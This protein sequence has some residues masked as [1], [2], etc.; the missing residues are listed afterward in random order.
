MAGIIQYLA[1]SEHGFAR[2]AR[3]M[4]RAVLNVTLPAPAAV[5]RP[6]LWTFLGMR[7]AYHFV[8]RVAFC[9]PLFKAYCTEYGSGV[10]TGVFL[11]WVQ[12]SGSIRLGNRVLLDGKS[13]FAFTSQ[14]ISDPILEIGDNT[15]VGH[16]CSF[17][18]GRRISIG[19]NCL[20]ARGVWMFDVSGH[21]TDPAER[22]A[23]KPA[24]DAT[25]RPITI[26]DNVWIGMGSQILPG[27]TIGDGAV[28]A[29]GSVVRGRV[30]AN[31]IVAGNPAVEVRELTP[32]S[33]V[34][35]RQI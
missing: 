27:T 1:R 6:V 22:L 20:I 14:Y 32:A 35:P 23:G 7:T 10:R 30:R 2:S 4:R 15:Y 19:R 34:T 28:V 31:T 16:D 26:G 24:P 9:E 33:D 18:V 17:S 8:K 25:V 21:P 12:G 11:H 13:G 29:S 3:R 5:V